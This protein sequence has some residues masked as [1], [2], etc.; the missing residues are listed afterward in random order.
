MQRYLDTPRC[1]MIPLSQ[2]LDGKAQSCQNTVTACDRCTSLGLL[3]STLGS[4]EQDQGGGSDTDSSEQEPDPGSLLI[5]QHNSQTARQLQRFTHGLDLLQGC[6]ILCRFL[7]NKR[8]EGAEHSLDQ[9]RSRF[10]QEFLDAKKTAIQQGK[11][12]GSGWLARYGACY[13]CGNIQAVCPSQG[14]GNCKYKDLI[15]PLCWSVLHRRD[16]A[17]KVL[18]GLPQGLA[19]SRDE[20]KYMLWLG[21]TAIVFGEQGTNLALIADQVVQEVLLAV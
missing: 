4:E 8:G 18:R 7:D 16:W 5:Q 14:Q 2:Y 19:A 20:G 6:C 13:R 12:K 15:M 11:K 17:A 21:E 10:R 3:S 9:C 1:R